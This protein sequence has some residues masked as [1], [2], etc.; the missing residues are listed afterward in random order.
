MI[1]VVN[2]LE[3]VENSVFKQKFEHK[4]LHVVFAV[5]IP[6]WVAQNA[7][8]A[9]FLYFLRYPKAKSKFCF[10]YAVGQSVLLFNFGGIFSDF[11]KNS[12]GVGV[13]YFVYAC[14]CS[15]VYYMEVPH[16]AVMHFFARV[17][18]K[19][20]S[21]FVHSRRHFCRACVL[22]VVGYS[23]IIETRLVIRGNG[24]GRSKQ[25][26]RLGGVQMSIAFKGCEFI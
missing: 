11:F 20:F 15:E 23:H 4:G 9:E 8:S 13:Y 26:V 12:V 25:S 18:F 17:D 16:S 21:D 22:V 7:Q 2:H 10:V 19:I 24:F 3:R 1:V 14:V 5:S 6:I